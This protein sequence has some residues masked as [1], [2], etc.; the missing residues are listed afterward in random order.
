M[1]Y[2]QP[3]PPLRPLPLIDPM[4]FD[5]MSRRRMARVLDPGL[6]FRLKMHDLLN[7]TAK[8]RREL[9]KQFG[10]IPPDPPQ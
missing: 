5:S 1:S 7:P 6:D 2:Y 3:Q 4:G 9:E 10:I 8:R